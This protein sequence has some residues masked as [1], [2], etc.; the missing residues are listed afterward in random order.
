VRAHEP[1]D[2]KEVMLVGMPLS[3][4]REIRFL[5]RERGVEEEEEKIVMVN[6]IV[7]E[8]EMVIVQ[9]VYPWRRRIV[10]TRRRLKERKQLVFF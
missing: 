2:L 6:R 9:E 4:V 5:V 10:I 8:M 7:E 3:S 1:S